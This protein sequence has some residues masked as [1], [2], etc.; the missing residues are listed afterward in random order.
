M[1]L[2]IQ[3]NNWGF[4]LTAYLIVFQGVS[5]STIWYQ[6]GFVKPQSSIY[7]TR[8]EQNYIKSIIRLLRSRVIGLFNLNENCYEH[9][10]ALL[11]SRNDNR[12]ILNTNQLFDYIQSEL[13]NSENLAFDTE[14]FRHRSQLQS[15]LQTLICSSSL[16]SMHGS[17]QIMAIFLIPNQNNKI[18]EIFPYGIDSSH[19]RPYKTLADILDYHYESLEISK[20][21][22]F[23]GDF[24][25]PPHLGGLSHLPEV[26]RKNIQASIDD[27]LPP[28][29]CCDNPHWLY[30]IYQ[31]VIVDIEQFRHIFKLKKHK[32]TPQ[33]IKYRIFNVDNLSFKHSDS[34]WNITWTAPWNLQFIDEI[35]FKYQ[36]LLNKHNSENGFVLETAKSFVVIK[37]DICSLGCNI[38]VRLQLSSQSNQYEL[39]SDYHTIP[40]IINSTI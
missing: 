21:N 16:F 35:T 28:H 38:W 4:R 18:I 22:S 14:L 6:Y 37:Q 17:E 32:T 34:N 5:M 1:R 24:D 27:P 2:H 29:L 10:K 19:Y 7:R 23:T 36:I 25:N 40:L 12:R 20:Q 9:P 30:R 31:D 3:V 39:I 15:V 13:A 26:E 8:K 33:T 11:I